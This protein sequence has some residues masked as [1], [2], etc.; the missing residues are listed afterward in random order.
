MLA[1]SKNVYEVKLVTVN[2]YSN[3]R[4][5]GA[6]PF[7]GIR[8]RWIFFSIFFFYPCSNTGYI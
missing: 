6:E 1:K 3:G 4:E 8:I 5:S 7:Y 2:W